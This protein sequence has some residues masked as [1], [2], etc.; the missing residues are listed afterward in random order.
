[1]VT[2]TEFCEETILIYRQSCLGDKSFPVQNASSLY[3]FYGGGISHVV[4]SVCLFN[5]PLIFLGN[6]HPGVIHRAVPVA[7]VHE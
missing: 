2:N 3:I 1:M 4:I 5:F 6:H 7:D